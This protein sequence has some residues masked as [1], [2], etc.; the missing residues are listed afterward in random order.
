MERVMLASMADRSSRDCFISVP[1][2]LREASANDVC[3]PDPYVERALAAMRADPARPWTVAT[4]A[5]VAGL[6][7]A[8]FARRFQRSTGTSP[9][10]W[11]TQH[12]LELARR[13]LVDTDLGIAEIAAE[14]GDASDFALSKAFRRLFGM[15]PGMFRRARRIGATLRSTAPIFRAAA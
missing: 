11:L 6:S 7:R 1:R 9:L 10:R 15:A 3:A 5:R 8:P 13:R 2:A 4:I 12:R 14:I